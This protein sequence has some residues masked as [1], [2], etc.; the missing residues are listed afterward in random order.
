MLFVYF[1]RE[2]RQKMKKRLTRQAF[3]KIPIFVKMKENVKSMRKEICWRGIIFWVPL[4][5]LVK[6]IRLKI[7]PFTNRKLHFEIGIPLSIFSWRFGITPDNVTS[8]KLW[9][10]IFILAGIAS[11]LIIDYFRSQLSIASV[12]MSE[13]MSLIPV[14]YVWAIIACF[15]SDFLD[16]P[17]ARTL[18]YYKITA[19]PFFLSERFPMFQGETFDA[20][21]DKLAVFTGI[22]AGI[23]LGYPWKPLLLI[24]FWSPVKMLAGFHG[25]WLIGLKYRDLGLTILGK[26][27]KEFKEKIRSYLR[28]M[29]PPVGIGR[30]E[31]Y[32]QLFGIATA[33]FWI[34]YQFEWLIKIGWLFAFLA[35]GAGLTSY[36]AH[37]ERFFQEI[38]AK[39]SA[40]EVEAPMAFAGRNGKFIPL[41]LT[42][43]FVG[44]AIFRLRRQT[45]NKFTAA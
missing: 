33:C 5:W 20:F 14:K 12:Q 1:H 45:Q 37:I 26:G 28:R 11:N 39:H 13:F 32:I 35:L 31:L 8:I 18:N 21:S 2:R 6:N 44:L 23:M 40:Y 10:S 41:A 24:F 3:T 17:L 38:N 9:A 15:F 27:S 16:G 4:I 19:C 30:I 29:I 43:F 7:I 42:H 25:A 36:R 34:Y 22:F